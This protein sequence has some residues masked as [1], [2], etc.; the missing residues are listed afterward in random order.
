[1]SEEQLAPV[2]LHTV[3][4]WEPT[5]SPKLGQQPVLQVNDGLPDLLVLGEEVVVIDSDL[6]ILLQ[7][8]SAGQLEHP[9]GRGRGQNNGGSLSSPH[10]VG[11][12]GGGKGR[13]EA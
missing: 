5:A 2:H 4:L 8:Q 7:R 6:Q 13:G 12:Q 10:T 11:A 3:G 9:V 1:M